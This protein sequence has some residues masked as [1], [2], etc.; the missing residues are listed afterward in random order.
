MASRTHGFAIVTGV[1]QM[2]SYLLSD[3]WTSMVQLILAA[4]R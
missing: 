2:V 3:S 1:C 4:A